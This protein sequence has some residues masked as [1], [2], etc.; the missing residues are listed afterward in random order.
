MQAIN[1]RKVVR[2]KHCS[3]HMQNQEDESAGLHETRSETIPIW[4]GFTSSFH[5]KLGR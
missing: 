5:H 1:V 3:G 2:I 4:W